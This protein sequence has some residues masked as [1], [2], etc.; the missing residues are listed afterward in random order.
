[1]DEFEIIRRHFVP[2][3]KSASVIVGVG[4]DGAVLRPQPG[5]DLVTVVDTMVAG[6]HFPTDL[7]AEHA[8]YRAVA[9]NLSDIAAMGARP[10]WMTLALTLNNAQTDWLKGF[11]NGLDS[12]ATAHGV[13][14]V[15]G[16]T[17]RGTEIVISVQITGEIKAGQAITRSGAR[18][19]DGIYVTGT[20]G[21]AA[22]GLSKLKSPQDDVARSSGDDF[23]IRRFTEPDARVQVGQDI[24]E[25]ATAAI[26]LSDGLFADLD[27]L[28]TA[29]GVGGVIEV[30]EIP[31]SDPFRAATDTDERLR[32]V[33][34]GGDDYELCFTAPSDAFE[35]E[36]R[37]AG[38]PV[39]RI[40]QVTDERQL[41]C[42]RAGKNIHYH[43]TGYRHFDES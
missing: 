15:G 2:A 36:S 27:K 41:T 23:L 5:L 11:A 43:D 37:I 24:A 3:T 1:M 26:D 7:P 28:L 31:L 4:D 34:A 40:G 25:T 8:G 22:L 21:D 9:V 16:D 17:T 14:L 29:S 33:L 12:A 39:T 13:E 42:T 20:I 19:G 6:V 18:V 10:R 30:N 32:H 35:N 38:V